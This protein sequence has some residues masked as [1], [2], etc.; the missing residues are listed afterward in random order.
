MRY[1]LILSLIFISN[2]SIADQTEELSAV[3]EPPELPLPVKSGEILEPDITITRK[4][5]KTI[6]EFRR[7]GEL[8]MIKIIP[9]IGPA[10]YLID[11]DGDGNMDVRGSDLDKG[12]KVNQ[13]KIFEWD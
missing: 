5:K 6:Q 10:Y 1:F 2:I 9:D 8:Y 13:W 4:G 3:P 11:I 7:N 12:T